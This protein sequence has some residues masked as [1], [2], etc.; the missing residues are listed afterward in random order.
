MG[1][2]FM[3][4]LVKKAKGIGQI[5]LLDYPIPQVNAENVLLRIEVAGICGSDLHIYNDRHPY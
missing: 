2:L 1:S 4:A 3:K 5:E